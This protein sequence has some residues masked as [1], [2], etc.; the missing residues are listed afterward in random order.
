MDSPTAGFQLSALPASNPW[1]TNIGKYDPMQ[2]IANAEAQMGFHQALQTLGPETQAKLAGAQQ[3]TAQAQAG[4]AQA[5][6]AKTQAGLQ[7]QV[8]NQAAPSIVGTGVLSSSNEFGGALATKAGLT[9]TQ[10]LYQQ[11]AQEM[12]GMQTEI[13]DAMKITDHSQREAALTAI[14]AKH[15]WLELAPYKS[16]ADA[17]EKN[18]AAAEQLAQ[19]EMKGKAQVEASAKR[20]VEAAGVN[21]QAKNPIISKLLQSKQDLTDAGADPEVLKAIDDA[22]TKANYVKPAPQT[23]PQRITDLEA[24]AKQAEVEGN[25]KLAKE[26]RDHITFFNTRSG[27]AGGEDMAAQVAALNA[28]LE[29]EKNATAGTGAPAPA[30][31]TPAAATSNQMPQTAPQPNPDQVAKLRANPSLAAYF[32]Q[33]FGPGSAA[34]I[35]Q[36]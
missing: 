22:I 8:L 3:Q 24:Q 21:A 10:A 1:P 9:R 36:P 12:P 20:G 13:G 19:E 2:P 16:T 27:K 7:G 15:P 6:N 35:L 17:I 30:A 23:D 26:L 4:T 14:E 11:A 32:D 31:G 25:P 18:R 34:K 28:K 33:K 5:Q 29:A